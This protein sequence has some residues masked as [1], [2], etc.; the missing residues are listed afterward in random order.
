MNRLTNVTQYLLELDR[1]RRIEF[2]AMYIHRTISIAGK[3]KRACLRILLQ[4]LCKS[5]SNASPIR[6][7]QPMF[8]FLP[9]LNRNRTLLPLYFIEQVAYILLLRFQ[10]LQFKSMRG[11][12]YLFR[13]VEQIEIAQDAVL[14]NNRNCVAPEF[15]LKTGCR[16][17]FDLFKRSR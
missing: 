13:I 2:I 9:A 17:T 8:W 14:L 6:K 16:V 11:Q 3:D 7:D 1:L 4:S 12:D 10:T 15:R 5:F